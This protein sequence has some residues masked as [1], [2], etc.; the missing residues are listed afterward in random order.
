MG[1]RIDPKTEIT[2][3]F[4]VKPPFRMSRILRRRRP[5]GV[6]GTALKKTAPSLD[7]LDA[8]GLM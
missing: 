8:H 1:D 6:S 3:R 4:H 7:M 2:R 5:L